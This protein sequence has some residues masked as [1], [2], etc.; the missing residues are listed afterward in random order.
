MCSVCYCKHS[1]AGLV[2]GHIIQYL[3]QPQHKASSSTLFSASKTL[4]RPA[5]TN[6]LFSSRHLLMQ[7][8]ST[9]LDCMSV[10]QFS[11][12]VNAHCRSYS[13]G[14]GDT[15]TRIVNFTQSF[16]VGQTWLGGR[17]QVKRTYIQ[18]N[19]DELSLI[20]I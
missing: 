14:S 9:L 18:L 6:V 7:S 3:K 15:S 17:T 19:V 16:C 4:Q 5:I 10:V 8:T 12:V 2:T 1:S 20:H 13:P 11:T